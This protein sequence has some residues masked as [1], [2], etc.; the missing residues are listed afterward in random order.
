MKKILL[1]LILLFSGLNI[2]NAQI[3]APTGTISRASSQLVLF[4]DQT[5]RLGDIQITN[6][7]DTEAVT[8]HVIFLA[9]YQAIVA[10]DDLSDLVLCD[11]LDFVDV[12]TP[13]DTHVY[14][15]SESPTITKNVGES[16]A[17]AGGSAS[18]NLANLGANGAIGAVIITPVVS[19]SDLSPISFQHLF[20]SVNGYI[21]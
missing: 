15:L 11:E 9:S 6:T 12:L 21:P 1:T 20:G 13:N 16:A 2:A 4:Y 18:F 7:N 5:G 19:E 3:I 10:D 8:I 14:D 17:A